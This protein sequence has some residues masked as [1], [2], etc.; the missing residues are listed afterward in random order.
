MNIW[1]E[2]QKSE[3]IIISEY[4]CTVEEGL[5][6]SVFAYIA[7]TKHKQAHMFK[8]SLQNNLV[9]PFMEAI[10]EKNGDDV[11]PAKITIFE[12]D[13]SRFNMSP[14]EFLECILCIKN[15]VQDSLII[16]KEF[17]TKYEPPNPIFT[18]EISL[19]G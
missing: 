7:Y 2:A 17:N 14:Q 5:A 10:K 6:N 9:T 19:R 15:I 8:S 1:K 3:G 4:Q 18:L 13:L 11:Y 12:N 16:V